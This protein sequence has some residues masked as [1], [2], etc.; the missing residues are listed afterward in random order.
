[1]V[2]NERE[3]VM[4]LLNIVEAVMSLCL[5]VLGVIWL[6]EVNVAAGV[7]GTCAMAAMMTHGLC[8]DKK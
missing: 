4:L 2:E 8:E 7:V 1:M 6:Y 5:A 3:N